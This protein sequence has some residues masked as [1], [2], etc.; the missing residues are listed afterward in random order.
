[1]MGTVYDTKNKAFKLSPKD[2]HMV[3]PYLGERYRISAYTVS[4]LGKLTREIQL[5]SD[6]G[7]PIYRDAPRRPMIAFS[8]RH[9]A[10]GK[11]PS[12]RPKH[13]P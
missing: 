5:L 3:V 10:G 9:P 8:S 12:T 4:D 7:Y 1:M 2:V 13:R 6:L 11:D